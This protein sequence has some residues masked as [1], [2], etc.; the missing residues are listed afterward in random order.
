MSANQQQQP[1]EANQSLKRRLSWIMISLAL[2]PILIIGL[3][4]H[5]QTKKSLQEEIFNSLDQTSEMAIHVIRDWFM[6]RQVDIE[7]L[8]ATRLAAPIL[9]QLTALLEQ[10]DLSIQETLRQDSAQAIANFPRKMFRGHQSRYDYV[11][12]IYLVSRKG[13]IVLSTNQGKEWGINLKQEEFVDTNFSHTVFSVMEKGVTQFSDLELWL[14]QADHYSGFFVTPVFDQHSNIIGAMAIEA[15]LEAMMNGFQNIL[16][17]DQWRYIVGRD[18]Y[19]RTA[20]HTRDRG[21]VKVTSNAVAEWQKESSTPIDLNTPTFY[22]SHTG[23]DVIGTVRDIQ[24]LG[25]HW[26]L[27]SEVEQRTAFAAANRLS[28]LTAGILLLTALVTILLIQSISGRIIKPLSQLSAFVTSISNGKKTAPVTISNRDEIGQL[29][30]AFNSMISTRN[31]YEQELQLSDSFSRQ[32]LSAATDFGIIATDTQGL[33]TKFNSGAESLLGYTSGEV[34]NKET[35]MLFHLEEEVQKRAEELT[36]DFGKEIAGFEALV[37]NSKINGSETRE[38]HFSHKDGSQKLVQ[39]TVTAIRN[40]DNEIIGYLGIAQDISDSKKTEQTLMRLSRIAQETNNG[41]IITDPQ[42]NIEWTNEGFTR[43]TGYSYE[44]AQHKKPSV[45]LQGPK[46]DPETIS[47]MRKALQNEEEFTVEIINYHRDGK[48]FWLEINCNPLYSSDGRLEGFM[49]MET[50]ITERKRSQEE[51]LNSLRYNQV[52]AKITTDRAIMSGTLESSKRTITEQM[53]IALNVERASIWFF[54]DSAQHLSCIDLYEANQRKHIEKMRIYRQE[55]PY[56]FAAALRHSIVATDDAQNDSSL[57]EFRDSYIIPNNIRS[58]LTAVVTG[59][60]GIIGIISFES[61]GNTRHWTSA[62]L[63]FASAMSTIVGSVYEAEKRREIQK[64]LVV[65]K[66]TAEN[67]DRAKSEFL[68]IMSHEIRT[69]MNGVIG[70]LNLLKRSQLSDI[71]SR[72]ASIAQSSAKSLLY[73]INDILDFSK[74]EAGKLDLE[75]VEFDLRSCI[76]NVAESMAIKAEEKSISLILDLAQLSQSWMVGDPGRIRQIFTNLIGN[77]LKFTPQGE[78]I[79]SCSAQR[80]GDQYYVSASVKDSGIGI[81]PDKIDDLFDSFT[82]ADASTTRQ[83]GGTGLGLAIC[84]RLCNMMNG[85]ISARSNLNEGS[86]FYFSLILD[87]CEART[88]SI[89]NTSLNHR[90]ILIVDDNDTN[91]EILQ[92]QLRAWGA[93]VTEADSGPSALAI[94]NQHKDLSFDVAILDMQMPEMDG[95][96]LGQHIKTLSPTTGLIMMTSLAMRNDAKRFAELGFEAYFTKPVTMSD[97]HDALAVV[98]EKGKTLQNASPLVTK[99]YLRSL[100]SS[101]TNDQVGK[102][103]WGNNQRILLVEDNSINQEV[104]SLMLED[105][106]LIA[107]I[108]SNGVEAITALKTAPEESPYTLILMDCQMPEMD[109]YECSRVIRDLEVGERYAFIPIIAMTANAMKGDRERCISAGMS[110]YLSKPIDPEELLAALIKW[111]KPKLKQP[112]TSLPSSQDST[113]ITTHT[114]VDNQLG[115]I[116]DKDRA[117]KRVGQKESRLVYLA[118]MFLKDM[119]ERVNCLD[120]GFEQHSITEI[121][122]VAHACKGVAL[123]LSLNTLA[124]SS[125]DLEK[126]ARD[127]NFNQCLEIRARFTQA[128]NNASSTLEKYLKDN[129]TKV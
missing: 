102:P 17:R 16:H 63:A 122:A 116:W 34:L 105:I 121:L 62:E 78:I 41:I 36:E 46:T 114:D 27:I 13:D 117:F 125:A 43:I 72:Q 83:Y 115:T 56:Y 112:S 120:K 124:E 110:D 91:R 86:E 3:F 37:V 59:S 128:F 8:A 33:I 126:S 119:P 58:V 107:D 106:G 99:H 76:E 44:F 14:D 70:M 49:A 31:K 53:A 69:P 7:S 97:L 88:T 21:R 79:I 74:V 129:E 52:L 68:A 80:Q 38:W 11:D 19:L 18:G 22:T 2:A 96:E 127:N 89:P 1:T 25:I 94:C 98:L 39:L 92:I 95:A 103:I 123:N 85:E 71:Q 28:T 50:D 101:S 57:A 118:E 100:P 23:H 9:Q 26:A 32:I 15:D 20:S 77:A 30:S 73:L 66:E 104:A 5:Q 65:A 81:P 113:E 64:Q 45:F 48:P 61:R 93:Q 60:D 111:I 108:A 6:V 84:K 90:R 29:A 42:G 12:G 82:Q 4:S 109:G 67:A 35:P 51:H 75:E 87:A 55:Y 24:L 10:S 47:H 54:D 40:D